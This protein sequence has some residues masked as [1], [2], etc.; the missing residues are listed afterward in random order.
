L[1][2]ARGDFE[3]IALAGRHPELRVELMLAANVAK[4]RVSDNGSAP[5]P[6]LRGGG[7]AIIGELASSLGGCVY[8]SWAAEGSGISRSENKATER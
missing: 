6:L 2:G 5:E 7:L 4:W 1:L 3:R 8:T